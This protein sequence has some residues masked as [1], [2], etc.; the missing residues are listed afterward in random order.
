[1]QQPFPHYTIGHFINQP[2]NPTGFEI[3]RFDTLVEPDVE[4]VHK[5]TFYEILWVDSGHSQQTIDYINY[6]MGPNALFFISPGQLHAFEEWEPLQGG[7]ILFS[8]DFFLINQQN[9]DKLFELS[10]L[11]NTYAHPL[12]QP[13]PADY[14]LIRHTIELL[15][16]EQQRADAHPAML[17][18]LLHVLLTQIQRSLDIEQPS[19]APKRATVLYKRLKTLLDEQFMHDRPVR[20]YADQL[21]VT[22]HHLNRICRQVTSQRAGEVIRSR[23]LLE[24]KRLLTFSDLTVSEV[25]G[26]LGFIDPSYFARLFRQEVGLSPLTFKQQ[27]SEKYRV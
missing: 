13:N 1:M 7:S 19:N 3:L 4:A 24:A 14:Q 15:C 6:E 12:L 8:S 9:Q 23:T 18:S 2:N 26:Q 11:D 20:Y 10:F 5:H 22:Q 21:N 17:Q 16:Q 25:S 27:M